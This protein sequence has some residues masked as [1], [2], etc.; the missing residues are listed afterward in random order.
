MDDNLHNCYK[1]LYD[2]LLNGEMRANDDFRIL[3]YECAIRSVVKELNI[4]IN[5][6]PIKPK[7][8]KETL[9]AVDKAG[10]STYDEHHYENTNYNEATDEI[11]HEEYTE[12][13][14]WLERL[15]LD[16]PFLDNVKHYDH[17][18][19]YDE[20]YDDYDYEL[21][22]LELKPRKPS[23]LNIQERNSGRKHL[24][25]KKA[26]FCAWIDDGSID[27]KNFLKLL[28]SIL[29]ADKQDIKKNIERTIDM[30]YVY[31]QYTFFGEKVEA[32]TPPYN[33]NQ[34]ISMKRKWIKRISKLIGTYGDY[35]FKN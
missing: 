12:R 11:E 14:I 6:N 30:F 33:E 24:N 7:L 28:P 20:R 13:F 2:E 16:Y 27:I 15:Y 5:A 1:T 29:D 32:I 22:P 10:I 26:G 35:Q 25:V 4:I 34:S 18:I 19:Y 23:K 17:P 3:Q 21:D 9:L 8:I 31:D